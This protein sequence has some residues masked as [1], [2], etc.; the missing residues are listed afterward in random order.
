VQKR[1]DAHHS[2]EPDHENHSEEPEG[3]NDEAQ[4]E[5]LRS[6]KT[7]LRMQSALIGE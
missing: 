3:Q 1:I 4:E 7:R 6:L 2:E 5:S